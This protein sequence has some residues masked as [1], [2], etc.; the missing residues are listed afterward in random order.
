MFPK[1]RARCAEMLHVFCTSHA[2]VRVIAYSTVCE[3][4]YNQILT[5]ISLEVILEK[6]DPYGVVTVSRC[7][8]R[9]LRFRA[10]TYL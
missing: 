10:S 4:A 7:A 3:H 6:S 5:T 8:Q 2:Q 9:N 1:V